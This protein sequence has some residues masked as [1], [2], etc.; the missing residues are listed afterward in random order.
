MC[1]TLVL[2]E[3]KALVGSRKAWLRGRRAARGGVG[4]A[5][6]LNLTYT[7]PSLSAF[8]GLKVGATKPLM[9]KS[10]GGAAEQA[11]I[12]RA[13]SAIDFMRGKGRTGIGRRA[14]RSGR[15]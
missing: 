12:R 1:I 4:K 10:L 14:A 13:T 5:M 3:L 6:M 8:I 9:M 11:T 7:V 15:L 2:W